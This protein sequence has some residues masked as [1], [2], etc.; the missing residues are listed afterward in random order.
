LV[1]EPNEINEIILL[2]FHWVEWQERKKEEWVKGKKKKREKEKEKRMKKATNASTNWNRNNFG[3]VSLG[4]MTGKKK[5]R[6]HIKR[7]HNAHFV[8]SLG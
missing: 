5:G 7:K 8:V 2:L 6:A 1:I 3:V 4:R